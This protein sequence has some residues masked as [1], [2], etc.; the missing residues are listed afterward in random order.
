MEMSEQQVWGEQRKPGDVCHG[1]TRRR[2]QFIPVSGYQMT[3]QTR[4]TVESKVPQGA[5]R[6]ASP[7]GDKNTVNAQIGGGGNSREGV[8]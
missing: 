6:G 2:Q 4:G 3:G 8:W 5:E 1:L 7:W